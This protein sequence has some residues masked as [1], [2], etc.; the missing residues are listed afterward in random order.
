MGLRRGWPTVAMEMSENSASWANARHLS[1]YHSNMNPDSLWV[2]STSTAGGV[3]LSAQDCYLAFKTRDAQYDGRF[4]VGV[5]STGIYCRPVCRVRLPK[6]ENCRFFADAVQAQLQGFRPCRRCRPDLAPKAYGWSLQDVSASLAAHALFLL[7][8]QRTK[9]SSKT[10]LQLVS[11][12][13]GISERHMR[14]I[15]QQHFGYS[16]IE[17]LQQQRLIDARRLLMESH[18]PIKQIAMASGYR[19]LRAFQ[20]A[21]AK[22]DGRLPSTLR[23]GRTFHLPP[24]NRKPS[25]GV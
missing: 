14:R 8:E 4:V 13:L 16:P 11:Q 18:L 1:H 23:P 10:T 20:A 21:F 7:E 12:R 17:F 2:Q 24:L 19:S 9:Q 3:L 5:T 15:V 6:P 25:Q 22:Y